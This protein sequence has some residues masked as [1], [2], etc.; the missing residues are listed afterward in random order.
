MNIARLLYIGTMKLGFTEE[1]VMAMTPRKFFV[2]YDEYLYMN[3]LQKQVMTIDDL[4]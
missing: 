1:Q 3:G 4:P 2:I